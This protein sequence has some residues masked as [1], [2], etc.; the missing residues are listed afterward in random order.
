MLTIS[1]D[2]MY[3]DSRVSRRFVIKGIPDEC[4]LKG[5]FRGSPFRV[6]D[7]TIT[8][9]PMCVYRDSDVVKYKGYRKSLAS[10]ESTT[11]GD[12]YITG[13]TVRV[14]DRN[15]LAIDSLT[16]T[17]YIKPQSYTPSKSIQLSS[18]TFDPLM[19]PLLQ[20]EGL[21]NSDDKTKKGK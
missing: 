13:L 1:P 10:N 20:G 15:G 8:L 17:C 18:A 16:R 19:K 5:Q 11:T 6:K 4:K 14:V 2:S 21:D 3:F 7:S 12:Y 9:E